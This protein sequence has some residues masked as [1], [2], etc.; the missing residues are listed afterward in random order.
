MD[1]A[2]NDDQHE[3]GN[4]T[5]AQ[6]GVQHAQGNGSEPVDREG[7]ECASPEDNANGM[8]GS[9]DNT[10]DQETPLQVIERMMDNASTYGP[11]TRPRGNR[12]SISPTIPFHPS[13]GE[14]GAAPSS[15]QQ[16]PGEEI[17]A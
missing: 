6:Q 10:P 9:H 8:I 11:I 16:P 17:P 1:P 12:W 15:Q 14:D 7:P 5:M 13:G 2:S 4:T 3:H